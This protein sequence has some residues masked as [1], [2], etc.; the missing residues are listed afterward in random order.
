MAAV[1]AAL[2][3]PL[4]A[5]GRAGSGPATPARV[6][7]AVAEPGAAGPDGDGAGSGAGSAG[8]VPGGSYTLRGAVLGAGGG[9][10]GPGRGGPRGEREEMEIQGRLVL[11]SAGKRGVGLG[12]AVGAGEGLG[13]EKW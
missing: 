13:G 7:V 3:A 11:V 8:A 5:L 2:L 10:A 4:L 12:G 6:E 1:R 9:R